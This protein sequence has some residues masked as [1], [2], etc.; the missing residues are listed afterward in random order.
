MLKKIMS[1]IC[2]MVMVLAVAGCT[3]DNQPTVNS[4]N[5]SKDDTTS[6]NSSNDDTS[7]KD[8]T[9]SGNSSDKNNVSY[10]DNAEEGGNAWEEVDN[11]SI[12]SSG[13]NNVTTAKEFDLKS[14]KQLVFPKYNSSYLTTLALEELQAAYKSKAKLDLKIVK[15]NAGT[16]DYELLVGKTSR[17]TATKVTA[18]DSYR[19]S[20]KGTKLMIDGGSPK[21]INAAIAVLKQKIQD[22]DFILKKAISGKCGTTG[23]VGDFSETYIEDFTG[24]SLS[25]NWFKYQGSETSV[26]IDGK[27]KSNISFKSL[28]L[29]TVKDGKLFQKVTLD[30]GP[31]KEGDVTVYDVSRPKLS[32]QQ[33]FW[34]QYG[35]TEVSVKA[36]TGEGM[37]TNYWLHGKNS[38]LGSVYCEYDILEIY[39]N[40]KWNQ[41]SPLA[42]EVVA[43]SSSSNGLRNESDWYLDFG[44]NT[45]AAYRAAAK[46]GVGG[47]G[48]GDVSLGADYHTYGMEWDENYYTIT[49]D[50]EVLKKIKYT[51]MPE[52]YNAKTNFTKAEMIDAYRQPVFIVVDVNV[53]VQTW[54]T[55]TTYGSSDMSKNNWVDDNISAYDYCLLY[56]KPG[57]LSGKTFEAVKD[58]MK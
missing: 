2:A 47:F 31:Y 42:W 3:N 46:Y 16:K 12:T 10:Y 43:D 58:K 39:G 7:S 22:G 21:A 29:S 27:K 8:D 34:F 5:S 13:G 26:S 51:D 4:G 24:N 45:T 57:Q 36:A 33:S 41:F 11:S 15:D 35:Y 56:Q 9:S 38:G 55:T 25:T 54:S 49:L 1:L 20:W 40:S 23:K 18:L 48:K 52:N 50:G 28:N 14:V 32:T 44:N 17:T 6:Q 37:G 19:I 30:K 53:G